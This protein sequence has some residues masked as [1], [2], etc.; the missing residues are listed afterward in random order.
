[1]SE[2]D[3]PTILAALDVAIEACEYVALE[4]PAEEDKE[5]RAQNILRALHSQIEK[6][7]VWERRLEKENAELRKRIEKKRPFVE[8]DEI[9]AL[10]LTMKLQDDEI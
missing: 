5:R 7:N 2:R 4:Y 6:E 9:G 10:K 1:V 8:A 3:T